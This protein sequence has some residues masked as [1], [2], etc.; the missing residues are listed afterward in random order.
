VCRA[1]GAAVA[2]LTDNGKFARLA[3]K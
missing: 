2:R 3:P 1:E